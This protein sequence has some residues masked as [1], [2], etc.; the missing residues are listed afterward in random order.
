MLHRLTLVLALIFP[1][2]VVFAQD[3]RSIAPRPLTSA[4]HAM[5][6]GDWTR[7]ATLAV[8]DGSAAVKLIEWH[9]LRAG[10]GTASQVLQFLQE[11]PD[12]PGLKRLRRENEA[13]IAQSDVSR[14][15][16]FYD[17]YMPQTGLGALS[18]VAA[19][20]EVSRQKEAG[21][22]L[23]NAWLTMDLS[24]REHDLFIAFHNA[25]LKPHHNAR[26]DMALWRGLQ[27]VDYMLPL[28]SKP[29]RRLAQ[30]WLDV[31]NGVSGAEKRIKALPAKDRIHAGLAYAK[32]N[33]HISRGEGDAATRLILRQSAEAQGL[34]QPERWAGRRRIMARS[35]MQD[36][37][38][39]LAY[40]LASSHQL[41][42]GSTFANL[43]WLSGYIALK[44]L[45]KPMLALG[46]FQ[47]FQTAV[48][49]PISLG[50]AGYWIGRAHEAMNDPAAARAAY[51]GGAEHQTS[52]YGLLAAERAD[53]PPDPE[54]R[55]GSGVAWRKADFAKTEV[56]QAGVLALATGRRSLAEQFF[57]HLSEGLDAGDLTKL[58]AA[59][60][61][62][63][64]PHLQVMLGKAAARRGII[65]PEAYYA[66]HPLA[67]RDLPVP[68][69]LALSIARRESEFD[70]VVVSGAGAQGLMQIL[71]GTAA[72]VARDLGV[73]DH[74]PGQ[75]LTDWRY[76]ARLGSAFLAQ[77]S[78]RFDG[79]IVMVAAGYNA[80]PTRPNQ[81]VERFG[82]PRKGEVDIVD[83]IEHIPFRETRNYVMRVA[84]SLPVY[85]ARLGQD[86][87]PVPFSEELVGSTLLNR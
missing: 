46:H 2:C 15:L 71:P 36:G 19:L 77:L 52:F 26:L 8:R 84:E 54:L 20:Q 60:Q 28:V 80:G 31:K 50:R 74:D 35:N 58:G 17:E 87:H 22:V 63:K 9:R 30:A 41:S 61:E 40:D 66:R 29:E 25:G 82:D 3:Q 76:N 59:L 85:R 44:Y 47:Q 56:F 64:E 16:T 12:W 62:F 69:E 49:S 4:L 27:D 73:D 18:L 11:N 21:D 55:A 13:L 81:W 70:P 51:A 75:V 32:F 34:G 1:A 78:K 86:M 67:D 53:L 48:R 83:W 72:D 39:Q 33:R 68:V 43:E 23:K 7:A 37:H 6:R 45:K 14:I 38:P 65:L 5:E 42:E 10:Q 57:V 24:K 79:N